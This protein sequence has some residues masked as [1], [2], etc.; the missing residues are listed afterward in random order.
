[1]HEGWSC[2][3]VIWIV[4]SI[5]FLTASSFIPDIYRS[6]QITL[7]KNNKKS[8]LANIIKYER[9]RE[10]TTC[11][12]FF[13]FSPLWR[14]YSWKWTLIDKQTNPLWHSCH[15]GSAERTTIPGALQETVGAL[16]AT[17]KTSCQ[18]RGHLPLHFF[19]FSSSLSLASFLWLPPSISFCSQTV[20]YIS[21]WKQR[22]RRRPLGVSYSSSVSMEIMCGVSIVQFPEW[23][24]WSCFGCFLRT[25]LL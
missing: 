4:A 2:Y 19:S 10:T 16:G 14:N 25:W 3:A 5:H 22:G 7:R 21:T 8:L 15:R 23:M 18:W 17:C 24:E 6:L 1:M 13:T 12:F 11:F 9:L 20:G